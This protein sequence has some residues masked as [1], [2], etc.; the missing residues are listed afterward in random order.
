MKKKD[1]LQIG[2]L[3][4]DQKDVNVSGARRLLFLFGCVEPDINPFTYTRGLFRHEFMHGHHADNSLRHR[5]KL[6]RRLT[7]SGVHS[8]W[9]WF[10]FGTLEWTSGANA[11][12]R[13]E[14]LG[15]D[16]T[17]G[18]AI[19]TLLEAPVRAIAEDDARRHQDAPTVTHDDVPDAGPLKQFGDCHTG[20]PGAGDDDPLLGQGPFEHATPV[21]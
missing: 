13:T 21:D 1:H 10:T 4:L 3:L 11:G 14:V 19:L 2:R 8:P 18:V 7:K 17:D 16:V 15:H 6:M 5:H 20:G 12:R 9:Q